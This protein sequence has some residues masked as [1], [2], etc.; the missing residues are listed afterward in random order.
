[1]L[2]NKKQPEIPRRRTLS[3]FSNAAAL[4]MDRGREE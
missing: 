1:M 3:V 4:G 2:P